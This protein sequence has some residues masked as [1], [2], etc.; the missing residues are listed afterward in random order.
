MTA[1][2][3]KESD[4]VHFYDKNIGHLTDLEVYQSVIFKVGSV[5][6]RMTASGHITA[7]KFGKPMVLLMTLIIRV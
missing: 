3:I 7:F 2:D 6:D 4:I 5:N 1:L